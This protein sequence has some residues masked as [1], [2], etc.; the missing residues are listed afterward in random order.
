MLEWSAGVIGWERE[1]YHRALSVRLLLGEHMIAVLEPW[2]E[3]GLR[4]RRK[5]LCSGLR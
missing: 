4:C 1:V 3:G 2:Q 5:P